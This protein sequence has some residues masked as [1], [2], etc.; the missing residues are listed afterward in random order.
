MFASCRDVT[1]EYCSIEDAECHFGSIRWA[2]ITGRANTNSNPKRA[3]VNVRF[4]VLNIL[5]GLNMNT[6]VSQDMSL[7]SNMIRCLIRIL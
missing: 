7:E 3:Y 1:V 4:F 5:G 6:V 2:T